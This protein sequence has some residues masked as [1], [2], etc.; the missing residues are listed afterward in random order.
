[1]NIELNF[2]PKLRGARSR[3]YRRRFLQVNTRWKALAE[4]YTMHSFAPFW[5]HLN[6]YSFSKMNNSFASSGGACEE[7]S[8]ACGPGRGGAVLYGPGESV[9]VTRNHIGEPIDSEAFISVVNAGAK[10]LPWAEWAV[11]AVGLQYCAAYDLAT[12]NDTVFLDWL[13]TRPDLLVSLTEI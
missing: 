1:M 10:D 5:N 13:E 12:R 4:I 6:S 11:H 8:A 7:I 9:T 3:L 2:S